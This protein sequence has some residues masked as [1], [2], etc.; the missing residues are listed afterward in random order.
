[1]YLMDGNNR[2]MISK[3]LNES[4]R[5]S[6]CTKGSRRY[7]QGRSLPFSVFSFQTVEDSDTGGI[8]DEFLMRYNVGG[9][10][11]NEVAFS[12]LRQEISLQEHLL[13]LPMLWGTQPVRLYS[14]LVPVAADVFRRIVIRE[15][16]IPHINAT[17]FTV[18]R[19]TERKYYEV[20]TAQEIYELVESD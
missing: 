9:I 15:G 4:D 6:G 10:H 16:I 13:E 11:I 20:C 12:K 17:D 5:L 1:M 7:L 2:I 18:K 8:P 14:G 3:A 19:W